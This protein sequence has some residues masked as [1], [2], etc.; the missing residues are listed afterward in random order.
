MDAIEIRA[1]A[2]C[3]G[4][5]VERGAFAGDC[6]IEC[7]LHRREDG[8]DD[9]TPVFHQRNRDRPIGASGEIRARAVD[10]V[11]HP[12]TRRMHPREIVLG[13]LRKPA[14][15][16]RDCFKPCTQ[17]IVDRYVGIADRRT[18]MFGPILY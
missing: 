3:S 12:D 4:N 15:L 9:R 5:A 1:V 17:K 13:L 6:E 7:V 18:A 14:A 10:R 11:D 16:G 2:C 8:A